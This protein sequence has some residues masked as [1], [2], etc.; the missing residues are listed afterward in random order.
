[1]GSEVL[2]LIGAVGIG[3][4]LLLAMFVVPLRR[5]PEE[6]KEKPLYE[7]RCSAKWRFAKGTIIVGGN[8]PIARV[9]FY[10]D[11]FVVAMGTLAKVFYS[12]VLSTSFKSGWL[13]NSITIQLAKGRSLLIRPKNFKKVQSLIQTRVKHISQ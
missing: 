6:K 13:S 8:I 12:E 1:M 10:D 11:Y 9:S 4:F 3:V 2:T 5:L 7:E